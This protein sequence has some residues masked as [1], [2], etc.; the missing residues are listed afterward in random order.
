VIRFADSGEAGLERL[1]GDI[2]PALMAVTRAL[3]SVG[4]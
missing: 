1:S 3:A 2:E 4:L